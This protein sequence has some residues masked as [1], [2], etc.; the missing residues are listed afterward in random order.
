MINLLSPEAKNEIKAARSNVLLVRYIL[1]LAL[2]T[3][4]LAASLGVAFYYLRT[5]KANAETTISENTEKESSYGNIKAKAESF[6]SSITDAKTVLDGQIDYSKVILNISR[7]MP[8]GS[9]LD[10][11]KL[12]KNSFGTPLNLSVKLKGENA[13]KQLLANFSSAP[14]V[15]N[16]SK[17]TINLSNDKTYPYTM[18]L[19]ITLNKEAAQQ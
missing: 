14:F 7:L 5:I 15:S 17:G 1:L 6:R 19:T 4:F 13:A 12:D 18:A 16:V 8:N 3:L 11:L 10:S 2:A 9:A